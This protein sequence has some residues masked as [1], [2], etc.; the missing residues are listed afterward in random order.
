MRM[1]IAIW[2]AVG[3]L[4][5][6]GVAFMI[7]SSRAAGPRAQVTLLSVQREATSVE[8]K[9][10]DFTQKL[11]AFRNLPD[12][13]GRAEQLNA[14]EILLNDIRAELQHVKGSTDART[15]AADLQKLRDRLDDAY[16]LIKQAAKAPRPASV[17]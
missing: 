2:M 8:R 16:R 9:L 5:V 10:D 3:V 4:V 11:A 6:I 17:P 12:A 14:I 7:A 15:A 13:A 1:R